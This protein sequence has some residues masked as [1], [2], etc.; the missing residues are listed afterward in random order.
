MRISLRS[1]LLLIVAVALPLAGFINRYNGKRRVASY[2][3]SVNGTVVW[4][5]QRGIC[6]FP[7]PP[8]PEFSVPMW[9]RNLVGDDVDSHIRRLS[10]S[11]DQSQLRTANRL[12]KTETVAL[13]GLTRLKIDA[14]ESASEQLDIHALGKLPD[15]RLLKISGATI[16]RSEFES[17]AEMED[18]E[19]LWI[20]E[21]EF[22][23]EDIST[24]ADSQHLAWVE[25][26]RDH[27]WPEVLSKMR[28]QL[29]SI[30]LSF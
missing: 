12:L 22:N 2:V 21:C 8:R 6:Y 5:H 30:Y 11:L 1:I 24:L 14:T 15:V 16:S 9:I 10:V 26:G 19:I 23:A 25:V 29:P 13:R 20:S 28:E 17:L 3:A 4:S 7:D 27:T 18:L